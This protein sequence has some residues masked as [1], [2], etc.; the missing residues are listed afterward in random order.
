MLL[1]TFQALLVTFLV[2]FT[3]AGAI[4]LSSGILTLL[5]PTG[6]AFA[7]VW[8]LSARQ[9]R[10]ILIISVLLAV[11]ALFLVARRHRLK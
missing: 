9:F 7:F 2:I 8:S 1:K 11:A 3:A 6:G 5:L 10:M 4:L